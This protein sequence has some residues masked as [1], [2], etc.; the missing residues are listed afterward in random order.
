[1]KVDGLETAAQAAASAGAAPRFAAL[2]VFGDSLSDSGNAGR[3]S[4]GPVWVEHLA[5]RLGLKLLPARFNGTI[6][7]WAARARVAADC[8]TSTLSH[9]EL[10]AATYEAVV[11]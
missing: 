7:P 8:S 4:N 11:G 2:Y 10:D 9:A 1:M 3:F 6:T 5:E